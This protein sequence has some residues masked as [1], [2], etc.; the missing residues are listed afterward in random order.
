MTQPTP[1]AA[2]APAAPF[3]NLGTS[4]PAA[5][6]PAQQDP[7][8]AAATA[9]GDALP[10]QLEAIRQNADL[11]E[12]AK[13][14]QVTAAYENHLAALGQHHADLTARRTARLEHLQARI[15]TGP[16]FPP[17][18]SAAD[19]AVLA[20]AFRSA[21]DQARTT[22]PKDRVGA[23]DDAIRFGDDVQVRALLTAAQDDSDTK[24]VDRWAAATGNTV[25]VAEIRA[26]RAQLAGQ[27]TGTAGWERRAFWAPQRPAEVMDLPTL[28]MRAQQAAARNR[29]TGGGINAART[30]R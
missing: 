25:H 23:L 3:W 7:A 18:A 22:L 27:D 28:R 19:R 16:G 8:I 29:P 13:A 14:E 11:S 21:L 4:E 20:T 30:Y 26:L 2:A 9:A 15:P 17:D 1:P 6:P 10:Q 12:L 24:L 5:M